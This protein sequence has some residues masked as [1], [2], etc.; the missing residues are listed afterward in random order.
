SSPA[1]SSAADCALAR[2]HPSFLDADGGARILVFGRRECAPVV[3]SVFDRELVTDAQVLRSANRRRR[4]RRRSARALPRCAGRV[5]RRQFAPAPA[6]GTGL[7][8]AALLYRERN[9]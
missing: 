7:H 4:D 6:C 3:L 8:G 9:L 1:V 2:A 5:P